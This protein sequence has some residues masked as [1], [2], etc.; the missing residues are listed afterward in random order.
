MMMLD[1]AVELILLAAAHCNCLASDASFHEQPRQISQSASAGI[2]LP[3]YR[4]ELPRVFRRREETGSAA[5]GDFM[6]V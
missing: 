6:D 5:L 1:L 3:L 2:H 4:R